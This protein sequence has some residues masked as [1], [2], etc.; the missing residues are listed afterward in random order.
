MPR[1]A[2][3]NVPPTGP[4]PPS[5]QLEAAFLEEKLE[6][7][8]PEGE[9]AEE[10]APK[11]KTKVRKTDVPFS[12]S[13]SRGMSK[14]EL[15]EAVEREAQMS[16]QDRIQEETADRKNALEAYVYSMRNKVGGAYADFVGEAERAEFSRRLDDMENWLYDE[17]EDL[18]KKVYIEKLEELKKIG[19]PIAFRANEA[20]RRGP[21]AESLRTLCRNYLAVAQSDS[22]QYAHIEAGEKNRVVSECSAA[23]QWLDEKLKLQEQTPK[24]QPPA[25]TVADMDKRG[26]TVERVCKP[27]MS[28]PAPKPTPPPAPAPTPAAESE[29]METDELGA[30]EGPQVAEEADAEEMA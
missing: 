10:D 17:G 8:A 24:T 1:P 22:P 23:L 13:A 27:I 14:A 15:D 30:E 5:T 11:T 29:P 18:E 9:A 6:E 28:K 2:L 16:L 20:D 19:D 12:V 4:S 21:V 26:E 7:P 25:L 3:T